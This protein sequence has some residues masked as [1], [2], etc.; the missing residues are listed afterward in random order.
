MNDAVAKVEPLRKVTLSLAAGRTPDTMDLNTQLTPYEFIFGLGTQGLT[1]LEYELA[2][3]IEGDEILFCLEPD[4][5]KKTF[6][7][8]P[9]PFFRLPS[10]VDSFYLKTRI[11]KIV[12]AD[13]R[14]IIKG[15]AG[16]ANCDDC[17]CGCGG[18]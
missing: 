18:H 15:L 9:M 8:L 12:P 6:E 13:K 14:E 5:I 10:D 17:G 16:I 1:P 7:H 3:K 2:E 4:K 11:M